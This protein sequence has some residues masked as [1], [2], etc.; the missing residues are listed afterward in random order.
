[1]L[2]LNAGVAGDCETFDV[3]VGDWTEVN[4]KCI[5]HSDLLSHHGSKPVLYESENTA[6][7]GERNG[8]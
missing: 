7:L 8:K 1:M 5:M 3:A 2:F 4:Y 6:E